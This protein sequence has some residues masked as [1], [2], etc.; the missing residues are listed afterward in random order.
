MTHR[1]AGARVPRALAALLALLLPLSAADLLNAPGAAAATQT[2]PEV[3][4]AEAFEGSWAPAADGL[5]G[6]PA[7]SAQRG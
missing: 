7:G 5:S 3:T 4:R 2:K 6:R 1:R